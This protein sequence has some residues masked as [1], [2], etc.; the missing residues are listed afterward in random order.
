MEKMS[1]DTD[2]R[3]RIRVTDPSPVILLGQGTDKREAIHDGA[4][5]V[6][7]ILSAIVTIVVGVIAAFAGVLK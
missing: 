3:V 4:G 6:W 1:K 5:G 2:A 7:L